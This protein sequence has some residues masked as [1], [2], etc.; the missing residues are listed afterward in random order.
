MILLNNNLR[1]ILIYTA[2]I[3]TTNLLVVKHR[4]RPIITKI[5]MAR[6]QIVVIKQKGYEF[7]FA[8]LLLPFSVVGVSCRCW[9][10]S[11]TTIWYCSQS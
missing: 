9:C 1:R 2:T 6:T 11:P 5:K 8:G 7:F 3:I 10:F 4:Q